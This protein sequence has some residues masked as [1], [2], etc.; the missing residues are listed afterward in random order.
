MELLIHSSFAENGIHRS[1]EANYLS[2][3]LM[4]TIWQFISKLISQVCLRNEAIFFEFCESNTWLEIVAT[5][6]PCPTCLHYT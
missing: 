2:S 6:V 5:D 4:I 1:R 3:V